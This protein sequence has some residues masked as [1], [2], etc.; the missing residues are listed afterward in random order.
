MSSKRAT[1][2]NPATGKRIAVGGKM[3]QKL[4]AEKKVERP[5]ELPD[6]SL[7]AYKPD[8]DTWVRTCGPKYQ[9]LVSGVKPTYVHLAERRLILR[10]DAYNSGGVG[11]EAAAEER[12]TRKVTRRLLDLSDVMAMIL[13]FACW[14]DVA[15]YQ[16]VSTTSQSF[17]ILTARVVPL[18]SLVQARCTHVTLRDGVK[19]AKNVA[20]RCDPT[21]P[22][23]VVREFARQF[24]RAFVSQMV[25]TKALKWFPLLCGDKELAPKILDATKAWL[26]DM[27][28]DYGYYGIPFTVLAAV[29]PKLHLSEPELLK[30]VRVSRFVGKKHLPTMYETLGSLTEQAKALQPPAAPT[31]RVR[32]IA[33]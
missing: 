18:E 15:T 1:V 26:T 2:R 7:F 8:D 4:L 5:G 10:K 25:Y 11:L 21:T 23:R 31:K 3:Y 12:I 29:L 22:E 16:R 13:E 9:G 32:K 17:H 30:Q 28:G 24:P 14:G 27:E 6:I 19:H 20:I 33:R